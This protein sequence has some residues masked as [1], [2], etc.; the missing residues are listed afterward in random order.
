V[1]LFKVDFELE[2]QQRKNSQLISENQ[3]NEDTTQ[4]IENK[5][6]YITML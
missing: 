5:R 6:T 3:E 4:E 2:D 1:E